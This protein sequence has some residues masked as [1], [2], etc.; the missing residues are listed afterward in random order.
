MTYK[1]C[2]SC[3]MDSTDPNISFELNG[4][5]NNCYQFYKY[6][7]PFLQKNLEN[8]NLIQKEISKIK[9]SKKSNYD[10]ILGLSGGIDSSYML[11]YVVKE[12]GLSPLVFHVDTG[13]NS[14]VSTTNIE[15]LAKTLNIDLFTVV[16]N[17]EEMRKFQLAFFKSGLPHLDTPQDQAFLAT[18]YNHSIKMNINTILNGGNVSSECVRHPLKFLYYAT[19]MKH[20]N[21]IRS[22]FGAKDLK[23]FPFSSI[24][25]H[26][27]WLRYFKGIKVF[28]PLNYIKYNKKEAEE[29]LTKAY[30]WIPYK[31]KHY[32]SR[33][34]RYYEGYWLPY[35]FGFDTRRP[36]YS[37][38][39]LNEQ[40]SRDEALERLSKPALSLDEAESE[41]HFVAQKLRI[42]YDE[43]I[44]YRDMPKKFYWDYKNS[45][46][47]FEIGSKFLRKLRME[48]SISQ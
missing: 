12:M 21:D 42:S 29:V 7:K 41:S 19:D 6:T 2:K 11:H 30:N 38:L 31:E 44:S 39:I 4:I 37:S 9:S 13:W 18:L 48:A 25:R 5:C 1:V 32:E 35:R 36:T 3:V 26:K 23:T 40:M 45:H 27:V 46:K 24:L 34:T 33:F 17:W 20:N 10:S 16:I 47:L 14:I 15:R 43:L 22:K 8:P 28:R